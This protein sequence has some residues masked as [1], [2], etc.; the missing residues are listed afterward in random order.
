MV[1]TKCWEAAFGWQEILSLI[2]KNIYYMALPHIYLK[3][4]LWLASFDTSENVRYLVRLVKV[5]FG[6]RD[7][8]SSRVT[9]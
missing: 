7:T 3:K 8:S 9:D 1:V 4:V 2:A 6:K 5:L